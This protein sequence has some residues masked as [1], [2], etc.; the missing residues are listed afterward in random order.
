MARWDREKSS[1]N[2]VGELKKQID[3]LRGQIERAQRDADLETASR[4]MYGELPG[5]EKELELACHVSPDAPDAA[6][7]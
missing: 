6:N 3:E 1:L 4:L 2:K 7:A 5:L